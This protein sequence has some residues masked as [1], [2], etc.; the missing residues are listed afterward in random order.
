MF[1][2]FEKGIK[3]TTLKR[4]IDLPE[5]V[6]IIKT[7]TRKDD[8][9]VIRRLKKDGDNN[10]KR[11]KETLP[12]ITPHCIVKKRCLKDS[13]S[14]SNFL[15]ASG[16]IYIDIDNV[17]NPSEFKNDLILRYGDRA[18]LICISAGGNGITMLF[19]LTNTITQENF[20]TLRLELIHSLHCNIMV[21]RNSGGLGR[22]M[23]VSYDPEVWYN[24]DN[25]I[26]LSLESKEDVVHNPNS[27]SLY[28]NR[29][30]YYFS[31]QDNKT[32]SQDYQKQS[33]Y[34]I[35]TIDVVLSKVVTKT[36]VQVLNP[37]VDFKPIDFVETYIP[38]VIKDGSKHRTFYRLIHQWYYLNPNI[39]LDYLYSYLFFIN[40]TRSK[41]RMEV[42]E[43]VRF[44]TAVV[45]EIK[46]S[47]EVYPAPFIKRIHFNPEAGV[48]PKEKIRIAAQLNG[49]YCRYNTINKISQ[50]RLELERQ[51]KKVTNR[52]LAAHAN[53]SVKTVGKYINCIPI[54]MNYEVSLWN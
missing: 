29:E 52:S 40:N 5:L 12:N 42:R 30:G 7:N 16:Y 15:A 25:R 11:I 9:G 20:N 35:Y 46:R 23:F 21:D 6:H 13:E 39:E 44:F 51:G 18:S 37:I 22:A 10:Y 32:P 3:D 49:A 28:Y 1:S 33:R 26:T 8:I 17:Q 36:E 50:A 27:Y 45:T 34:K 14:E 2:Y 4:I 19:R 53:L 54:D 41:P 24:Y 38:E 43:L 48:P 31:N 47:G